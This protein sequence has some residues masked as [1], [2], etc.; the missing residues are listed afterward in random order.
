MKIQDK[1]VV[2]IKYTLT[3]D[4]KNVIDKSDDGKF[5]FLIGSGNIIPG[6]E[7]ALMDKTVGDTFEVSINPEEAYGAY[8]DELIHK[9][10]RAQFPPDMEIKEGMQFQGQ[11]ADGQMTVVQ[12][13]EVKGDDIYVDNNHPL[14][15][16]QLN[17]DVEV[18]EV[19]EAT[20]TEIEHGHVHD[21][22][23]NHG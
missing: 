16:V 10:P 17:F 21:G 7:N 20:E 2:N 8:N 6:L 14:A 13:K 12:V 1:N 18:T 19:R 4:D 3:D 15:G 22:T 11:T 23:E 9:V 5:S